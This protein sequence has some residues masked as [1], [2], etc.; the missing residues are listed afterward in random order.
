[1]DA[2]I[3]NCLPSLVPSICLFW[4]TVRAVKYSQIHLQGLASTL[5][6]N[7]GMENEEQNIEHRRLSLEYYL[8]N[9]FRYISSFYSVYTE[10]IYT[11]CTSCE[12]ELRVGM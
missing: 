2:D 11:L 9:V 4:P 8:V 1:M 6:S 5:S 12:A 7:T 3:L 10:G